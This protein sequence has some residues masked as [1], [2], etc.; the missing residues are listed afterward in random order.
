MC[1]WID[2]IRH[3]CLTITQLFTPVSGD[4]IRP[5]VAEL[6]SIPLRVGVVGG[7]GWLVYG[8]NTALSGLPIGWVFPLGRGWQK[9][10]PPI[11]ENPNYVMSVKASLYMKYQSFFFNSSSY[12]GVN[13]FFI[14]YLCHRYGSSH[15][16]YGLSVFLCLSY[17]ST[18]LVNTYFLQHQHSL[19]QHQYCFSTYLVVFLHLHYRTFQFLFFFVAW[20][21]CCP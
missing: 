13:T 8:D 19:Y 3:N 12:W 18:L 17:L 11:S 4:K 15:P 6:Q 16:Q 5:V 20:N 9:M 1:L 2:A 7:W 14:Q 10:L 21:M